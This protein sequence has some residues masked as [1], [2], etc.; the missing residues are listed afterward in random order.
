MRKEK[1]LKNSE[2]TAQHKSGK[3]QQNRHK[4]SGNNKGR[5]RD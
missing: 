5:S 3:N 4:E 2:L 1:S